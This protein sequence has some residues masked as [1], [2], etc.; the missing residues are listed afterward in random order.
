MIPLPGHFGFVAVLCLPRF[1]FFW[2][3]LRFSSFGFP[4]E[5]G[6]PMTALAIVSHC[7]CSCI[8]FSSFSERIGT[9]SWTQCDNFC[10]F[11]PSSRLASL[12]EP[13]LLPLYGCFSSYGPHLTLLWTRGT[14]SL[15]LFP[16]Y[17]LMATRKSVVTSSPSPR[18]FSPFARFVCL[19]GNQTSSPSLRPFLPLMFARYPSSLRYRWSGA[20]LL[21]VLL[22]RGL[23]LNSFDHVDNLPFSSPSARGAVPMQASCEVP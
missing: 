2:L 22:P 4:F 1:F 20:Y 11:T 3:S 13:I 9:Y 8:A 12:F 5:T 17:R 21:Q 23:V 14:L 7:Y 18:P 16:L 10:G 6:P 19:P 15:A